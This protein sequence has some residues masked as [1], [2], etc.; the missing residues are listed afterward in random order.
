MQIKINGGNKRRDKVTVLRDHSYVI[1]TYNNSVFV[2]Y[3]C[4]TTDVFMLI[5]YWLCLNKKKLLAVW[6]ELLGYGNGSTGC[7]KI[8]SLQLPDVGWLFFYRNYE[9]ML[10]VGHWQTWCL[11]TTFTGGA[12]ILNANSVGSYNNTTSNSVGSYNNTTSNPA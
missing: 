7:S 5:Q 9:C 2:N 6:L 10:S 8:A 12:S 1:I 11:I 4:E 3:N